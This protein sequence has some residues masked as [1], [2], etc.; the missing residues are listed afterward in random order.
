MLVRTKNLKKKAELISALLKKEFPVLEIPLN[1]TNAFELLIATILSAQTTDAGVNKVTPELF[2]KYSTPKDLAEA[3]L[4][5][6]KRILRPTGF[7]N[8]KAKNV[9]AT[10]Q[11]IVSDFNGQV[12]DTMT[13]LITLSGVAR[14]VASVVLWQW[15][16]KNEGFT[17]DTHVLRLSKWFGLS[18]YTDAVRVEKDLMQLF[19]K[20]EWGSTSLRLIFLGRTVLTARGPKHKGTVW[21]GLVE[22]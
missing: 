9:K 12:P 13:E 3:D 4:E 7:F 2:A 21:E 18:E 22:I 10:A 19:P 15:F 20:E 17:V 6:L 14:K 1:H 5:D 16:G 11:K 8:T